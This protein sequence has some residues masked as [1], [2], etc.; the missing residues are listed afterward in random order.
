MT[1]NL[2]SFLMLTND[3]L[4][5]IDGRSNIVCNV[6]S[7]SHLTVFLLLPLAQYMVSKWRL[8]CASLAKAKSHQFQNYN[9]YKLEIINA[10]SLFVSSCAFSCLYVIPWPHP[11]LPTQTSRRWW[12]NP[13]S[14]ESI[15][16]HHCC[17][18]LLGSSITH[19]SS[20]TSVLELRWCW[21]SAFH[22]T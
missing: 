9:I 17:W 1:C 14:L 7:G 22:N 10:E 2:V 15:W 8:C 3:I 18:W 20:L 11:A 16:E 6:D 19:E 5:A 4:P 12:N 21:R 13:R